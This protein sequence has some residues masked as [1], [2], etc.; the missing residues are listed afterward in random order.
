MKTLFFLLLSSAI[1]AQTV[2]PAPLTFSADAT[3]AVQAWM[4]TQTSG[5]QGVTLNGA[6]DAVATTVVVSD[7]TNISGKDE[8]LIDGEAFLVVSKTGNTFTVTRA[9]LGTAAA[10]H[11]NGA[12]I[13][14]L[15]YPT[16]KAF[17]SA[18]VVNAVQ[19]IIDISNVGSFGTA[20][21]AI[22]TAQQAKAMAKAAAIQ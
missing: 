15:K 4:V 3:L 5:L 2:N 13:T 10:P 11:A 1:Y 6:I 16:I 20:N 22:Q 7:A 18:C 12:T 8:L 21:A 9:D 17:M 19:H 14:T